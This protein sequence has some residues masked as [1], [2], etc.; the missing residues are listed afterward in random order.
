M[1][2][3]GYIMQTHSDTF[4]VLV[5]TQLSKMICPLDFSIWTE[6]VPMAYSFGVPTWQPLRSCQ[7]PGVFFHIIAI[8]LP[9]RV[10]L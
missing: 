10:C 5:A 2:I 6:R 8:E 1:D 3:N 9:T 7:K 4:P